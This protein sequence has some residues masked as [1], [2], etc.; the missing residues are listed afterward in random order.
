[1]ADL[2]VLLLSFGVILLAAEYFTNSV[3]WLGKKLNLSEGAVGSVLAAVGTAMPETM[4]PL[5]ALLTGSGHEVSQEI[6]I[7]AILGAPF[8]LGT[9]AFCITGIAAVSFPVGG[10][11]RRV[12]LVDP[13]IMERDLRFFLIVYTLAIATA[14]LPIH[15]LKVIIA[16]GLM[17]AYAIYAYQTVT[18]G[19]RLG[20]EEELHPL[21]LARRQANPSLGLIL[22]QV[23]LALAGII[24]GARFFVTA[25]ENLSNLFGVPAF[26]LAII[27][28]PLATELPEKVNS[29]I[30]IRRGKDTL[31]LGNITGAMVFQ[32]SVIPAIGI[33]LTP[34]VLD[35]LALT[36]AALTLFSVAI[37]FA[38]LLRTNHLHPSLLLAGGFYY[39]I[40]LSTVLVSQ[41]S[42]VSWYLLVLP[43][44]G[45][46]YLLH[47]RHQ[48]RLRRHESEA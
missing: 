28:V 30:W 1:M 46:L 34:W 15:G 5:I 38:T 47:L 12:M 29:V 32:S 14:F 40:F 11:P 19:A 10:R 3:E 13:V 42:A 8:M 24:V 35:P 6:G 7:G 4:I 16:V 18:S 36:S 26:I 41:S 22:G 45:A 21:Y 48:G 27:I 44:V 31:A 43:A 37:V 39:V 2:L 20:E 9:L 17:V 33:L 23:A 25:I